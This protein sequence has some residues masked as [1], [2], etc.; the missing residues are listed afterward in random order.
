MRSFTFKIIYYFYHPHNQLLFRCLLAIFL[1]ILNSHA[2]ADDTSDLLQG[3]DQSAWTT[4]N[5]TGKKYLYLIEGLVA[6]FM[7]IKSK[8]IMV[9]T[10]IVVVAIFIN[11]ILHMAGQT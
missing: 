8:N 3:T 4:F 7:Y 2:F 11:I 6:L 5:G 9:L 1:L 10:G